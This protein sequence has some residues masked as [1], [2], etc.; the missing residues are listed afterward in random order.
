MTNTTTSEF[1]MLLLTLS[2]KLAP[3]AKS[4]SKKTLA[5]WRSNSC[6]SLRANA[7]LP[8]VCDTNTVG[9]FRFVIL[10]YS[11]MYLGNIATKFVNFYNVLGTKE[12]LATLFLVQIRKSDSVHHCHYPQLQGPCSSN[13]HPDPVS[14]HRPWSKQGNQFPAFGNSVNIRS[15]KS[16]PFSISKTSRNVSAP[17]LFRLTA[18]CSAT[19]RS[20]QPCE[21]NTR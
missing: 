11:L 21:T 19:Q 8:D 7:E 15:S 9:C 13:F 16:S 6:V 1:L 3:G 12:G 18:I 2:P 10:F 5:P 17:A 14:V 4:A 20:V